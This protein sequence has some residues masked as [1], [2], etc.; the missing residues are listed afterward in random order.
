MTFPTIASPFRD[1]LFDLT[2]SCRHRSGGA[3][4]EYIPALKDVDSQLFATAVMTPTGDMYAFGD[5]SHEFT[6]QSMCKPLAYGLAIEL[7]GLDAVSER[8]GVEPSGDAFNEISLDKYGRP[9]NPMINAGAITVHGL[10]MEYV[11]PDGDAVEVVRQNLSDLAGR[12]LKIDHEVSEG[13]VE[14]G[15]RNRAIANLLRSTD[16]I[17]CDPLEAFKGYCRQSA[18]ALNVCDLVTIGATL[19]SGG[20]QPMTGKRVF[21]PET[22]Q[23]VLSVMSTSGMYNA[24]G[25]WMNTVGIPAKSGVSGGIVGAIPGELA[26]ASFSPPLDQF[27][28][29][30][31]GNEFFHRASE[32][33]G[34]HMM[35]VSQRPHGALRQRALVDFDS[36]GIQDTTLL[37]LY[38]DINFT[39]FQVVD[40][41]VGKGA[42]SGT[43][44]FLDLVEVR[45]FSPLAREL[46]QQLLESVGAQT[47]VY[48]HDPSDLLDKDAC[49]TP[50]WVDQ[51]NV[52]EYRSAKPERLKP[53]RWHSRLGRTYRRRR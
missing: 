39:S 41:E 11:G 19:A 38:G 34:L 40:R 36:D 8:V 9:V 27:G 46:T 51:A 35:R 50:Q 3:N 24:A 33:L 49:T 13:E 18:V 15:F 31:R 30:V 42:A 5:T 23:W 44:L 25:N 53:R 6:I 47:T 45:S 20:I 26:L 10:L 28:N 37:R 43:Q 16:T 21:Q 12:E 22:V 32:D 7:M 17:T 48:V 14:T 1:T 52:R 4:A 2:E 29:S